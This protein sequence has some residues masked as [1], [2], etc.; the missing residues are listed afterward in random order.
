MG[1]SGGQNARHL[2]GDRL[3]F[4][5]DREEFYFMMR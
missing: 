3:E 4:A 2:P 5:L 1:V